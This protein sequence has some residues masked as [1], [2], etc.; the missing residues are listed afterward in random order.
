MLELLFLLLPVAVLYGWFIGRRE[1]G[2]RSGFFHLRHRREYAAGVNYLLN[3]EA[4][5][6]VDILT[7]VLPLER[8]TFDLQISLGVLFRRKGRSTRPSDPPE[9]PL[10][11]E[12]QPAAEGRG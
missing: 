3:D 7:R 6:A 2:R 1:S 5:K 9:P 8:D 4:D 10:T 12:P 11:R